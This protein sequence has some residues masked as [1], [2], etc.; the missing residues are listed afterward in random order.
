MGPE[1]VICKTQL[2]LKD[3]QMID[4]SGGFAPL[5]MGFED[6]NLML[7]AEHDPY[8]ELTM[9]LRIHMYK[10]GDKVHPGYTYIATLPLTAVDGVKYHFYGCV[11]PAGV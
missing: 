2:E 4:V 1:M 10:T 8:A 5:S 6:G 11:L 3:V 7:Y 9:V